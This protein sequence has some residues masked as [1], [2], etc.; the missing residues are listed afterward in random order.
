MLNLMLLFE[1]VTVYDVMLHYF[2]FLC[3]QAKALNEK[4]QR[5]LQAQREQEERHVSIC[6]IDPNMHSKDW[7]IFVS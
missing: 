6:N 2:T 5:D 1:T 3:V 7:L 4:N